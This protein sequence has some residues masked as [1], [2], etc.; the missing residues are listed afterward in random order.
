MSS[1]HTFVN[2][3][4]W[5]ILDVNQNTCLVHVSCRKYSWLEIALN[6][7]R[8]SYYSLLYL[9][10]FSSFSSQYTHT[11][12]NFTGFWDAKTESGA[13]WTRQVLYVI[14]KDTAVFAKYIPVFTC[15][16]SKQNMNT[17]HD[18]PSEILKEVHMGLTEKSDVQL[19]CQK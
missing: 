9:P 5:N 2:N 19:A 18:R 11:K 6:F 10:L 3:A 12:K 4:A 16:L 7:D 14:L 1:L 13:N 15:V 17:R 8:T